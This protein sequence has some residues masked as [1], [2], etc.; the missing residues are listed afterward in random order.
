MAKNKGKE[1]AREISVEE[2]EKKPMD[3]EMIMFAPGQFPE[4]AVAILTS[5]AEVRSFVHHHMCLES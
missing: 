5:K 4:Y 3:G 2:K 1:K